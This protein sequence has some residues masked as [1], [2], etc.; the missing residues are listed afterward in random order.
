MTPIVD[1][2]DDYID[3]YYVKVESLLARYY[4]CLIQLTMY[5]H[6]DHNIDYEYFNLD[7][8]EILKEFKKLTGKDI[9]DL[10]TN[11]DAQGDEE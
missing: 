1:E 8:Q 9:K 3:P 4:D 6:G 10:S 7:T 5:H 11:K 2:N